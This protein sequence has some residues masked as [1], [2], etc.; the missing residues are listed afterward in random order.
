MLINL[1]LK[2]PRTVILLTIIV[3]AVLSFQFPKIKI[4]T[5]PENMLA[6]DE[7]V[8]V[9]H[10]QV[11]KEF[12]I[13]EMI[14]LGIIREDGIFHRDTLRK[15]K[16]ITDSIKHIRGVIS[17][18]I[19]SLSVTNNVI[20]SGG[21]LRVRPPL[22]KLPDTDGEV[23]SLKKE[24][25]DNPLF[26]DRLVSSDG[27]GAAIYIPIKSKD[28][29]HEVAQEIRRIIKPL[30]GKEKFYMAGLPLAEDTFGSE[31]FRQMAIVAPLAGAFLMLILLI[32]FRR[33]MLVLPAMMV[34]MLSVIWTMGAMIGLGFTV[35]I[36]SS[37]IPVFL[38]PIAV[39]DSVHVLSDFYEHYKGKDRAGVIRKV[40]RSLFR[41]M[42]YTSLT[43][44]VGFANLA[45]AKIPP[46][47]VF[48]LFVAFGVLSAWL[49][50]IT[51][52]PAFLSII[53][54]K[55]LRGIEKVRSRSRVLAAL[56]DIS[57][58]KSRV[59]VI[60]GAALLVVALYGVT[61]L[62][63]ND[64]PV[65]WF[66]RSHPIR[67]ADTVLNKIIGGTYISYLV[68]EGSAPDD[69]K[70]PDVVSYMDKL[71]R[72]L[73]SHHLVGKTTSIADVVKRINYVLHDQDASYERVPESRQLIGQ[74]LFLF[75][76]SSKPDELD[77]LV[78]YDYKKANLWVQLRSGDNRDMTAVVRSVEN[79]VKDHPLP[80]GISIKWSGLPYLNIVWQKLMVS[81][82]LKATI[83]SYWVVFILLIVL[84]R[85]FWWAIIAILPLSFSIIFSYGL[86][87]FA[88]KDYDMPIAVCSTLTLGLGIDF[89]IHFCQRFMAHFKQSGDLNKTMQWVT[90][91]EP[92]V[93]IARNAIVV[94]LGFL[95][96]VLATLTPYVTVGLFF[97][98]LALFAGITTIFFLPALIETF[99]GK[100]NMM[101][102]R[103]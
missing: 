45:W 10:N 32:I 87:G 83:G 94:G 19:L 43:T 31:M 88:G 37:M 70:R 71:Q 9:F 86:I 91:G 16:E 52:L 95:P 66:K 39:C 24:L 92:N 65:K 84:F 56:S 50:T 30:E 35:H 15:I 48:G 55:R 8:R 38:M 6:R 13:N 77:N 78:D 90:K 93:A 11:K 36:M 76:M 26:K 58:S 100:L 34:A 74:Y 51:F 7:P 17:D 79:Y 2:Y 59:V 18:D 20:A 99:K 14:V 57:I 33:I 27:R 61:T 82:M 40:F 81:G 68:F 29:A 60:G 63:V 41:P 4:D 98:S 54:E 97:G 53:K 80:E 25:L 42:L 96:L 47:R 28:I 72:Y 49:L 23:E 103:V 101:S 21:G 102:C 46:V 22:F 64:N 1:S 62:R 67:V 44:A 75:L 69:M 12:G 73:H 3:T 5:D 89:A 85:S